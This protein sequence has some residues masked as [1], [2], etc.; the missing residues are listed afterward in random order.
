MKLSDLYISL[1]LRVNACGLRVTSVCTLKKEK[2][3]QDN[4]SEYMLWVIG[5]GENAFRM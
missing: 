2:K 5:G 4:V 1:H 3:P